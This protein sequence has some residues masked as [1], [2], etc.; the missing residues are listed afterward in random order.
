VNRSKRSFGDPTTALAASGGRSV[1]LCRGN[2]LSVANEALQLSQLEYGL[3]NLVAMAKQRIWQRLHDALRE[4]TRRGAR[5][6]SAPT[7]AIVDSQPARTAEG[8]LERDD[9]AVSKVR[10]FRGVLPQ[11]GDGRANV[12]KAAD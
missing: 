11:T 8:D 10:Q 2:G 9:L 7:V 12:G 5:K 3:R 6:K 4:M 1:P